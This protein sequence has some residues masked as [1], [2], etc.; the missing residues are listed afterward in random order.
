MTDMVIIIT[1]SFPRASISYSTG[2]LSLSFATSVTINPTCA[3]RFCLNATH[4]M[5]LT[6]FARSDLQL[7]RW[8]YSKTG[9]DL[10]FGNCA[11][12]PD[13]CYDLVSDPLNDQQFQMKL[14]VTS[15]DTLTFQICNS[16]SHCQFTTF[17]G[18]MNSSLTSLDEALTFAIG[19]NNQQ[20]T[21]RAGTL[22][23]SVEFY[24][25]TTCSPDCVNGECIGN[26]QCACDAGWTGPI[27]DVR[28]FVSY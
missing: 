9:E 5:G 24:S 8:Q 13:D 28:K 10:S 4:L 18:V 14:S 27:C 19:T 7:T 2:G 25:A 22:I 12:A 3:E 11:S 15:G 16:T 17:R 23:H 21:N 6:S 1:V 20:V 26:D